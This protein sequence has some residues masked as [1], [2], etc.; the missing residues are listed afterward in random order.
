MAAGS[1]DRLSLAAYKRSIMFAALTN[2][3]VTSKRMQWHAAEAL[4]FA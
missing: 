1:L 2:L 3:K 4:R